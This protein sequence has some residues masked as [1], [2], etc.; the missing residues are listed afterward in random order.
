MTI[1]LAL[2]AAGAVNCT[3]PKTQYEMNRC[4]QMDAERADIEMT[5]QW[6]ITYAVMKNSDASPYRSDD[7]DS[8]AAAL[9]AAQRSWIKFKEN[10]C[11]AVA[12]Q[13]E[14]GSMQPMIYSTCIAKVTDQRTIQLRDIE[15]AFR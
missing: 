1:L 9:L 14:G 3:A 6:N 10:H 8:R 11:N 4:K 7:A 2:L 15:K 12:L 5:R 13:Y